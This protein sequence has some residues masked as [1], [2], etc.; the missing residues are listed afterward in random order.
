MALQPRRTGTLL[1]DATVVYYTSNHESAL[2]EARIQDHLIEVSGGLPIISVSQVPM[3]LGTNICVGDVGMSNVN[4]F[5]QMQIGAESAKTKYVI[6]AEADYLHPREFFDFR[7]PDD[8][9]MYAGMPLY[10]LNAR[11]G[12]R[13]TFCAKERGSEGA[14]VVE[15]DLLLEYLKIML[16]RQPQWADSGPEDIRLPFL[17]TMGKM[18]EFTLPAP[19]IS[20][21]TDKQMHRATPWKKGSETR[22]LPYWGKASDLIDRFMGN[23]DN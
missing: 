16:R 14:M 6:T 15:R 12:K 13:R 8:S 18:E 2:F 7:P 17:F 5:R 4:I 19:L 23:N 21:R 11:R 10:I 3:T 1:P 9:I 22:E 20:F